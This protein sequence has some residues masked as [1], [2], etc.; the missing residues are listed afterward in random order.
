MSSQFEPDEIRLLRRLEASGDR[1]TRVSFIFSALFAPV[2]FMFF[3]YSRQ[4][5][6]AITIAF[7]V[8][9]IFTAWLAFASF[10]N[11]KKLAR[12]AEKVLKELEPPY[13]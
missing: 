8:L 11:S 6:F 1:F 10:R 12:I 9:L 4:D 5:Y 7:V 13:I 3:G 2:A